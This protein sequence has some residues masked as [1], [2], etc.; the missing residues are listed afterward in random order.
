M[1]L[2]FI[3][4]GAIST[5]LVTGLCTTKQVVDSIWVSPRNKEKSAL[6]KKRFSQVIVGS[7][8]QAVT[9]NSDIIVLAFL[10]GDLEAIAKPLVVR[11]DH[12]IVNLLSGTPNSRVAGI[13]NPHCAVVR[14]V[15][16]PCAA[17]HIGPIVVYPDNIKVNKIFN[18]LGTVISVERE[19]QLEYLSIITALMAPYFETLA[20]I[21]DWA[22]DA[23]VD[24]KQAADYTALMFEALSALAQK[25]PTGDLHQLA[26]ESM[27]PGGLNEMARKMISEAGGYNKLKPVLQAVTSRVIG[28]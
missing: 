27:T 15:P 1:R 3:G 6:L 10:P 17:E 9:D 7:D 14:A 21:T 4:T 23:G 12:L 19:G 11:D 20:T 8:N 16:L 2:G 13:I 22:T 26:D 5:A 24:Q 18:A 25:S 28:G